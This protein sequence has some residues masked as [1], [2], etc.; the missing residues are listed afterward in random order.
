MV[1]IIGGQGQ[2]QNQYALEQFIESDVF[3]DLHLR[4]REALHDAEQIEKIIAQASNSACVTCNEIGCGVVPM[5]KDERLW[6][7][8]VGAACQQLAALATQVIRM[9]CGIPCTLKG[10]AIC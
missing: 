2:G 3:L 4:I 7:D 8:A 10:N 1:L 5:D 6:R 9:Q